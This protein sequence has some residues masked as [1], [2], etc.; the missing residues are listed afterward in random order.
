M[1]HDMTRK[2]PLLVRGVGIDLDAACTGDLPKVLGE[3]RGRVAIF[4][5]KVG[6]AEKGDEENE[7]VWILGD[8]VD[9][10]GLNVRH[11]GVV[12]HDQPGIT[13][14]VLL[15]GYACMILRTGCSE[16][17]VGLVGI[18]VAGGRDEGAEARSFISLP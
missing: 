1:V 4:F 15:E 18:F 3:V 9:N 5:V 6:A 14:R 2:I 8:E 10:A 16:A 13:P 12:R 17:S 11:G 7:G